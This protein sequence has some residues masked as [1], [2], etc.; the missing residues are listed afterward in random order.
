MWHDIFIL[1]IRLSFRRAKYTISEPKYISNMVFVYYKMYLLA[2]S[3][4]S[5]RI[6]QE[7]A[8]LISSGFWRWKY[9]DKKDQMYHNAR[10]SSH[11]FFLW[12]RC[13]G[14][15]N[16]KMTLLLHASYIR[17][18]YIDLFLRLLVIEV[19]IQPYIWHYTISH[20]LQY[21]Q[22]SRKKLHIA[23]STAFYVVI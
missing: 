3:F 8:F 18:F 22:I 19:D 11:I 20:K 6:F 1:S 13:K 5:A 23:M 9:F 17:N 12:G 21:S 10:G 2:E 7:Y 16:R 14:K 4:F 15:I